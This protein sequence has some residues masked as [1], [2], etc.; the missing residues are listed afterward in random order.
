MNNFSNLVETV[1]VCTQ[2]TQHIPNVRTTKKPTL[3]HIEM[4]MLKNSYKGE[5]GYMVGWKPM[6]CDSK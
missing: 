5:S 6:P 3:K 2:E 1:K 4:K